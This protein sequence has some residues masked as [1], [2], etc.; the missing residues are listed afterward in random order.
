[1]GTTYTADIPGSS[2]LSTAPENNSARFI[3]QDTVIV[4]AGSAF[5]Y[6][7]AAQDDDPNDVLV[8]TFCDA[9]VGGSTVAPAPN[10]PAAP[11][12]GTVPY[13]PPFNATS[14]M[15]SGVTINATTGL[16]SGVAPS[17]GIYVVTVC[18]TEIRN[19]IAIA[20]QRKDLQIKVGDCTVAAA[21]LNPQ[22]ITCDGFT[23]SFEN[24]SPSP[25]IKSY[26][27]DF[28][29]TTLTND[30]SDLAIPTF[31]YPDTG[32][33][34]LKLVTNRNMSCSDS[35]TAKVFVF[36]GF[37]PGFRSIGSCIN[38]PIQ[39]IDTTRT[40][41]GIVNSWTWNFGD[42]A[43]GADTSHTQNPSWLY[44][45]SGTQDVTFI[46]TN[47]K[48]CKDTVVQQVNV[49]DKPII[50]MGFR[51]TLICRT[52]A[53]QLQAS[54]IGVFSW[55]PL[56]NIINPNTGTP[57]V[58]P[59]TTTMY[60]VTL[61]ENGC[62]NNDS[63]RVR[64][65]NAVTLQAIKDTTICRG[66][67]IQLNANSDGLRFNWSPVAN[68]NNPNII[69]PIA[70]TVS[71]TT[72]NVTAFI[73][74]CTATDQVVVTTVPYP[75]SMAGKDLSLCYN[76]SGQLNAGM[77]G[78]S[79]TWSPVSYLSNPNVLNP[80][81]TPPR[82][83]SY[84]LSVFD[85]LG[86]PKPGKDTVVVTVLPRV[87]AFAGRDTTIVVGQPLQFNASGGISYFWSPGVGL[88][89]I[90]I[91]NP[92]GTY[93]AEID[94][95]RYKVIVRDAGGCADSAFVMVK[96]F[97]TNPYIFVPTAFTPNNDGRNDVVR[98]IAV[99]IS[100]INYFTIY[101]RWGQLLFSTTV[102]GKGW[103]GRVNGVLQSTNTFVWMVSAIDYIGKPIFL[104]GHTTLIR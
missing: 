45:A 46:V 53:V 102:N 17:F 65:V 3:G 89:S 14:P 70:T 35:T 86:C 49:L 57:T 36:P 61:N 5:T 101:N 29:V 12:Y 88:S 43:T 11:P 48:G 76:T 26:F 32:I 20:T 19:G 30:T 41:Y 44:S 95:I 79:F 58:N 15:G 97:K 39:F 37:F 62:V 94:S 7:F 54:G 98:P 90:N 52:D 71:T 87:R 74:S 63:A 27:W 6:S 92:V 81:V 42:I 9:Y 34:I 80:V 69:N 28:G 93:G 85:T 31:T 2:P 100:K 59:L 16:I 10:P 25:L 60:R 56:I 55:T 66:D 78:S 84:V 82:T 77:L 104:K 83:T 22:Y 91:P 4:C 64:V 23:M 99:G 72:Y 68:L 50:T 40:D 1:V 8:Y 47:S 18:V 73:G 33:F 75:G 103:D 96:I 13:Q 24:L 67:Q 51:D 21:K 38:S